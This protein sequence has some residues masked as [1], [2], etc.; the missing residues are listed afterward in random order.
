M[1]TKELN[2]MTL[3][4]DI[5]DRLF[6][7]IN[8]SPYGMDKS[9][10]ATLRALL[11]NRLPSNESARLLTVSLRYDEY[12]LSEMS[13][14]E[15]MKGITDTVRLLDVNDSYVIRIVY[16][17]SKNSGEKLL[18]IIRAKVGSGKRY[19]DAYSLQDDLRIYYFKKLKGLFYTNS[20]GAVIFL[21][22]MDVRRFH[23]LQM[24]IP[25][26][27]SGLFKDNPLTSEETELLKGLGEND[28]SRYERLIEQFAQRLDMRSEIIRL[29]LAGFES[30]Y[31]R[32]RI[33]RISQSIE[34]LQKDYQHALENLR[35]ISN[36][37]QEHQIL[38]AGMQC[39]LNGNNES[40]LM[41]YFLCNK[42]LSIIRVDGTELEFVVNGYAD[43]YDDEAFET[44]AGNVSSYLFLDSEDG[45]TRA[46]MQRLYRAIFDDRIYR[47]RV[48]AAY[49]ADMSNSIVPISDYS[50]P[51]ESQT[52]LPNP[53]I[54]HFGCIGGY[55][56]RFVELMH[57]HD[58]VGAIDQTV[59]SARN[60]N[61]HD[62]MVMTEL[63]YIMA[64]TSITC[65]E[66]TDG[67]LMTPID[68]IK[69]L[70][71]ANEWQPLF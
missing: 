6:A 27:L 15:I 11:Y 24:M 67:N 54:Q 17:E 48:C 41:E 55:A 64:S 5:A 23:A 68:A 70:E 44:Y 42:N 40:E 47:L 26:F 53:H 69:K 39:R 35:S 57:N 66:D 38:L 32:K 46:G 71:E 8:A 59:V 63:A 30:T 52:Y 28:S 21:D 22:Y 10:A 14:D 50:F 7:N 31:E 56:S 13:P 45:V 33:S 12:S 60:L 34:K 29:R 65:I 62:S 3:V 1:F 9:F 49:I 4:N 37:M 25:K 18:D 51:L 20:S 16:P 43:V 19:F 58:Y 2:D 36:T 61:F